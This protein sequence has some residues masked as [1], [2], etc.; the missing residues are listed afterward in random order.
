MNTQK[1]ISSVA[2]LVDSNAA[3]ET[4]SPSS[5]P[6][7]PQSGVVLLGTPPRSPSSASSAP[8]PAPCATFWPRAEAA[9]TLRASEVD[10]VAAEEIEFF[11]TSD[12]DDNDV[13]VDAVRA[14]AII[15]SWIAELA[16]GDAETLAL[17][18]EPEP[19]PESIRGEGL[20]YTS[21]Y[22]LVLS[23]ASASPWRPY[24]RR[25]FAAERIA[26]EQLGAAVLERGPRALR[27]LTRRA[28]WDFATAL[29]AYAKARGR[30]PSVLAGLVRASSASGES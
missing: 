23:R 15:A 12:A 20:D 30:A 27:H 28:E 3:T 24:R 17:Y 21:G 6:P 14:R 8:F 4:P 22:A 2:A 13:D 19:W 11:F 26:S 5:I 7:G 1:S 18:Y 25:R 10:H 16:P 9:P 29:R